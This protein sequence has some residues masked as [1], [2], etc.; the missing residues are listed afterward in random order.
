MV[1]SAE[2]TQNHNQT[3]REVHRDHKAMNEGL[4]LNHISD[5][6]HTCCCISLPPICTS[7]IQRECGDI[8]AAHSESSSSEAAQCHFQGGFA[9]L[10]N[11]KLHKLPW[12]RID[13][14][15]VAP[16]HSPQSRQT[17]CARARAV[18]LQCRSA[19][20]FAPKSRGRTARGYRAVLPSRGTDRAEPQ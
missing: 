5:K 18:T 19:P 8:D 20:S 1:H 12:S 13:I 2:I 7:P 10:R 4:Q 14:N 11:L 3:I 17:G 16:H 9:T 15:F 6:A